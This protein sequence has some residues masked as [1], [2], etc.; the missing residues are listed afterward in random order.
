MPVLASLG[1]R[2]DEAWFASMSWQER[3]LMAGRAVANRS[4]PLTVTTPRGPVE[5]VRQRRAH[6]QPTDDAR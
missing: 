2:A 5:V 1:L 3:R 4:E 6:R